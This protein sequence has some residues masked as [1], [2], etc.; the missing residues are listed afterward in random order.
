MSL[1][2]SQATLRLLWPIW[3][4]RRLPGAEGGW[5]SRTAA[6][7]GVSTTSSADAGERLP[8]ASRAL[9]W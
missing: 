5:V 8:A 6:K 1:A 7:G 3:V 4:A 9:I 2:G